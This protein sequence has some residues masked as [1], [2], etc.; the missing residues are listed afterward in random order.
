MEHNLI[1]WSV[2]APAFAAYVWVLGRLM[3][4]GLERALRRRR[5]PT[6]G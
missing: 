5:P 4:W 2:L 3:S 6:R 1:F